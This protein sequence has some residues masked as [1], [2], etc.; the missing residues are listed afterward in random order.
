[1]L[2]FLRKKATGHRSVEAFRTYERVSEDQYKSVSKVLMT[3]ASYESAPQAQ[4]AEATVQ[5]TQLW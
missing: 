4:E 2:T 1:M 3:N 5:I